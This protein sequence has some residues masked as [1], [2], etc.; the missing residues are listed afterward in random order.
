M[1]L[2][3]YWYILVIFS[4]RMK[5]VKDSSLD[6]RIKNIKLK[7]MN[8][9]HRKRLRNCEKEIIKILDMKVIKKILL[10]NS[11]FTEG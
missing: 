8:Y 2:L 3:F 10:K 7:V 5:A 1:N 11:Y 4:D 9:R 6:E